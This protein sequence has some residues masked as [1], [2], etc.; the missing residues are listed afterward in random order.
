MQFLL[1]NIHLLTDFFHRQ[2]LTGFGLKTYEN[3]RVI[4]ICAASLRPKF[5]TLKPF[6]YGNSE[7]FKRIFLASTLALFFP[8]S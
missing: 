3:G 7:V 8:L 4:S 5:S 6:I 1:R 2:G